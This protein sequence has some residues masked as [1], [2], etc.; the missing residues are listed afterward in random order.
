MIKYDGLSVLYYFDWC[1]LNETD[2]QSE[3]SH[4]SGEMQL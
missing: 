1:Q 2:N 3:P 4:G